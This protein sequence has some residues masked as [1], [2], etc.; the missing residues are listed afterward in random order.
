MSTENY[1]NHPNFGLLFRVCLVGEGQE[2]FA[3]L[4]AHRLFFI[5]R[6][7]ASGLSFE[8]IGRV[9]SKQLIE[10]RLRLIR[11]TGHQAEYEQLQKTYKQAF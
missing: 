1:L 9:E 3:T 2:L 8:P 11:R 4:Y 5:V 7:D 10:Q 6:N